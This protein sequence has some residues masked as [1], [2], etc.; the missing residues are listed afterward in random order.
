[1]EWCLD[2]D[3]YAKDTTKQFTAAGQT[4]NPRH[5]IDAI[6]GL[7]ARNGGKSR[8]IVK[9]IAEI[10]LIK[11]ARNEFRN[12][13]WF[14]IKSPPADAHKGTLLDPHAQPCH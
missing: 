8:F 7:N 13:K 9:L 10:Q 4:L 11:R 5:T 2:T 1:M 6:L 12:R 3:D 14:L